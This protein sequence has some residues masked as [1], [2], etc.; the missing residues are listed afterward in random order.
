MASQ[1]AFQGIDTDFGKLLQSMIAQAA[2]AE[3]MS[4]LFGTAGGKLDIG[5]G[6]GKLFDLGASFLGSFAVGTDY[7]PRD[8][9]AMIHRGERIVTAAENARGGS[10]GMTLNQSIVINGNADPATVRRAAGQGARQ[11]LAAAGGAQRYVSPFLEERL[12]LYVRMGASYRDEFAVTPIV[13]RGGG[14]HVSLD[15]PFP[16]R[17]FDVSFNG[18]FETLWN[19]V[20]DMY[21][22]AYG[23][24]SGF[25]VRHI[26]DYSTAGNTGTPTPFDQPLKLV[27]DGVYQ[28]VKYYGAGGTPL[29]IGLPYR[30]LRKPVAGT[31]RVA[32]AGVEIG[33]GKSVDTTT[34]LVSF[35]ANSSAT[36]TGIT[37]A[38]RQ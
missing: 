28:L 31:V 14:R 2:A 23:V 18:D 21:F 17:V 24:Y 7:V 36:V 29:S 5:G 11:A 38:R 12:T 26:D 20:I 37:Q 15:H 30:R 6:F 34:G 8:G 19:R 10:S 35:D 9:L 16:V 22:R 33:V 4:A 1:N 27:S 3:I 32:V 25:R 13:T